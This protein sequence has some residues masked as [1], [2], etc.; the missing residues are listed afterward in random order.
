[1]LTPNDGPVFRVSKALRIV[2]LCGFF[3]GLATVVVSAVLYCQVREFS[4]FATY[5]SDMGNTPGW[6]QVVFNTGMLVSA[7][8][9]YVFLVFLVARL[10]HGGASGVFR[11]AALINGALVVLGSIG[12]AAVPFSMNLFLHK[13]SAMLYFFGTVILQALIAVQELRQRLPAVLPISTLALIAAYL[14]FASLFSMVGKVDGV[15]RTTPVFW[16]WCAFG[17]VMFWLLAHSIV[18]GKIDNRPRPGMP[19]NR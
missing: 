4:L 12:T 8:L 15:S 9:R 13:T 6:P 11:R 16:E 1:M 2:G 17:S 14:I 3:L 19:W 10:V 7:P 5:L 18:L